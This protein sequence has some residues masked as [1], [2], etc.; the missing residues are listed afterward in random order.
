MTRTKKR[1]L[2]II[3]ILILWLLTL[4]NCSCTYYI[5]PERAAN[6]QHKFERP[7]KRYERKMRRYER[8]NVKTIDP[9]RWHH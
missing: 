3:I 9:L 7:N 8:R 1:I 2:G 5:P 6:P 4:M